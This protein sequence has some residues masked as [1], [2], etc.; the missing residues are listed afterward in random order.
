M[1]Q[2]LIRPKVFQVFL[3]TLRD[4]TRVQ[5]LANIL[6]QTGLTELDRVLNEFEIVGVGILQLKQNFVTTLC[7]VEMISL[8]FVPIP[9]LYS[10]QVIFFL[11]VLHP[12]SRLAL[13]VYHQSP[14]EQK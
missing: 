7:L 8:N 14:S 5:I 12:F 9:N 6:Q 1:D 4:I 2:A 13:R 11:H 3:K 10:H